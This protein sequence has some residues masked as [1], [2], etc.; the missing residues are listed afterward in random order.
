MMIWPH[1]ERALPRYKNKNREPKKE[2]QF[3]EGLIED[4]M[5]HA[6]GPTPT[7]FRLHVRRGPI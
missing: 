2:Q 6:V 4:A 3:Y 7:P 5:R 1:R